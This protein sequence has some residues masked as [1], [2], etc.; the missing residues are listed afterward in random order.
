M[1]R[2]LIRVWASAIFVLTRTYTLWFYIVV[3]TEYDIFMGFENGIPIIKL[4]TFNTIYD[5]KYFYP[6]DPARSSVRE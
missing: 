5:F 6:G 3:N 2:K 1:K 4:Y